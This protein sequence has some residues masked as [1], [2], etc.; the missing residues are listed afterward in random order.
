MGYGRAV[1]RAAT[2]GQVVAFAEAFAPGGCGVIV[3]D[4]FVR[5]G[6]YVAELFDWCDCWF[7]GP[8]PVLAEV[9][10]PPGFRPPDQ[11]PV[12]RSAAAGREARVGFVR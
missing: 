12:A 9:V 2:A 11:H 4:W 10:A 6:R 8:P 1:A 5:D 7:S 3:S